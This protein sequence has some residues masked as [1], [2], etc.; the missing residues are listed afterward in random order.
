MLIFYVHREPHKAGAGALADRERAFSTELERGREHTKR[1]EP[2]NR[3]CHVNHVQVT[4][5]DR[6]NKLKENG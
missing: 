2:Q 1:A 5:L 3:T 6:K 4:R